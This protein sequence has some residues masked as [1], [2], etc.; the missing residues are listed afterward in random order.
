MYKFFSIFERD[1]NENEDLDIIEFHDLNDLLSMPERD[2][3]EYTNAENLIVLPPHHRC[4]SHTLN[5]VAV[6]DSEKY[7]D[8]DV[9]YKKKYRAIFAKLSKLWSKQ[10]QSTQVADKI[11]D[12]CGVY[13][14]TPVITR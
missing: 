11:K 12:I 5:L 10:N 14:K 9:L 13:L 4:V 6:K 2:A 1:E 7:L 8:N 3:E